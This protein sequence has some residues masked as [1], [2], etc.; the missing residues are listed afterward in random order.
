MVVD[1]SHAVG[2]CQMLISFSDSLKGSFSMRSSSND[3]LTTS[4]QISHKITISRMA[5]CQWYSPI[6]ITFCKTKPQRLICPLIT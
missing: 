2:G 1:D 4:P 6:V 3:T 5:I